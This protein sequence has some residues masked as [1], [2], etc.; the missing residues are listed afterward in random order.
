MRKGKKGN[1][2]QETE[3]G[4]EK[5]DSSA[6]IQQEGIR[7]IVKRLT[8]LGKKRWTHSEMESVDSKRPKQ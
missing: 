5:Q 2:R 6:E 3:I 4:C 7:E 1:D 8:A